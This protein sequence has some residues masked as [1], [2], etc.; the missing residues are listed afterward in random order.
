[1]AFEACRLPGRLGARRLVARLLGQL[2]EGLRVLKD[3]LGLVEV[4]R[5]RLELRLLLEQRLRRLV[6]GPEVGRLGPLQDVGGAG[7]LPLDVK[8]TP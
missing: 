3:P 7:A 4:A 6:V 1:M 5:G 8:A 2:V